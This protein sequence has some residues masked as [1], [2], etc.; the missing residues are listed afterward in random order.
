MQSKRVKVLKRR[1]GPSWWGE[2]V[3]MRIT[4]SDGHKSWAISSAGVSGYF[5]NDKERVKQVI[6]AWLK[7]A[8]S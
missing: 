6:A 2:M 1:I 5:G 4:Y 8:K 3:L 7:G